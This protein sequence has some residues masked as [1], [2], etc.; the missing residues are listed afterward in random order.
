MP[1]PKDTE[2][3]EEQYKQLLALDRETKKKLEEIKKKFDVL[4]IEIQ[5]FL[6]AMKI[7]MDELMVLGE[8]VDYEEGVSEEQ[9][10]EYESLKAKMKEIGQKSKESDNDDDKFEDCPNFETLK[11]QSKKLEKATKKLEKAMK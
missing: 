4:N 2:L 1:V 11:K 6:D 5:K 9:K 10:K 8:A 3:T 7:V